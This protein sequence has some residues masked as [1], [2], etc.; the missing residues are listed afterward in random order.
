MPALMWVGLAPS[1]RWAVPALAGCAVAAWLG[2][3]PVQPVLLGLGLLLASASL[4]WR[5]HWLFTWVATALPMLDLA[6]WSGRTYLDEFDALKAVIQQT[7]PQAPTVSTIVVKQLL[8]PDAL[9]EIEAIAAVG[10][11]NGLVYA[12]ASTTSITESLDLATRHLAKHNAALARCLILVT[13][14]EQL[15]T[16]GPIASAPGQSAI[17]MPCLAT[18]PK[19]AQVELTGMTADTPIIYAAATGDP[20]RSGIVEQCRFAYE[21]ISDQLNKR[22]SSLDQVVK[23]TEFIT[24]AALANYRDTAALRRHF[25]EPPFPAA[26]GVICERLPEP[27]SLISVEAVAMA[28]AIT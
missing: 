28:G 7:L 3:F 5:P 14:Q 18:K 20:S 1:R 13:S 27:G 9:I 24:P 6:P 26:T 23:T 21:Q 4:A 25:F 17:V 16:P 15:C 22:G 19:G 11:R 12:S 10:P 2:S 8:R